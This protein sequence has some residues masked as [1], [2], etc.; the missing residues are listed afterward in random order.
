MTLYK[1]ENSKKWWYDF[2]YHGQRVQRSRGVENKKEAN[3]I[4][5]AKRTQLAKREVGIEERPR[6]TGGELLD[7]LKQRWELE[8][9]ASVQNLSLLR[10]AKADWGAKMADEI[11]EHDLERYAFKRAKAG[12]AAATTNRIFQCLRRAFNLAKVRW[13]EYELLAEDNRRTGFFS[14][15]QMQN[16]LANLP[17]DGLRDYVDFSWST[18]IRKSE[19]ASLRWSFIEEGQ[20]VVPPEYCKSDEPHTIPI[21]G[22]LAAILKRRKAAQCFDANG[23]SQLSEFIFHRGDGFQIQEFRKSWQTACIAAGVGAMTCSTCGSSG[24][25][26]RCSTCKRARK[27]SGKI[28]HDLRRSFCRDAIRSGT[29]QS[30]AMALSGHRTISVYCATTSLPTRTKN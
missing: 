17:D 28:F 14:S 4:E 2:T 13:P 10:S 1:K 29:P 25:E 22:N 30:V 3:V 21:G 23:V 12:Y 15:E 7:R 24:T 6:H 26:K 8:G 27:Y 18:G 20:I 11:D 16:V 5:A 19:A 9:K